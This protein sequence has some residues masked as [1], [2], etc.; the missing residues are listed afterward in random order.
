MREQ[1]APSRSCHCRSPAIE[2]QV[3]FLRQKL[4]SRE[5][6]G[7]FFYERQRVGPTLLNVLGS[8]QQRK[9]FVSIH[10]QHLLDRQTITVAIL[11]EQEALCSHRRLQDFAQSI[12]RVIEITARFFGI[13]VRPQRL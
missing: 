10:P 5:I 2:G 8:L 3:L 12:G 6:P 1:P 13:N 11:G 7:R 4:P 9:G